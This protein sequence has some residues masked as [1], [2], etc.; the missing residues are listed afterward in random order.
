[1]IVPFAG[2]DEQLRALRLTLS[3]LRL[4]PGDELIISDNRNDPVRTPAYARNCGARHAR[5]EWLVFIDADTFPD[6]GLLDAYFDPPPE[7]GTAV[8]AGSIRDVALRQT[9][10]AR[11]AVDR[12]RMSQRATLARNGT[13]YAQTANCAVRREAFEAVCGFCPDARAG[14]DADLCFRLQRAGWRI[15]ERP[16]ARVEHRSRESVAAWLAQ[17]VRHGSGAAWVE[18]RWPGE[19]SAAGLRR[20]SRR[21]AR[22]AADGASALAR[23]DRERATDAALD[24]L[25][26]TAFELGRLIPNTR[27]GRLRG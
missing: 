26:A 21:L 23:G 15:E 24:L 25:G 11:N 6:P 8:L 22:D 16:G 9:A 18:R 7:P 19:L 27:R 5:G 17:L 14:E 1:M 20:L 3:K 2:S 4:R 10:V 13:P 12:E